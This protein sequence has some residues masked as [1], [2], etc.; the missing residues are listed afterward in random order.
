MTINNI[1][2]NTTINNDT[3]ISQLYNTIKQ[4]N[5]LDLVQLDP[6]SYTN[7]R[8]FQ[9]LL[10]IIKFEF[11]LTN[12]PDESQLIDKLNIELTTTNNTTST[13]TG[14]YLDTFIKLKSSDLLT[15]YQFLYTQE[16]PN[17]I[18]L[19]N[20]KIVIINSITDKSLSLSI[21]SSIQI[22]ILQLY[23]LSNFDFRKK[24]I[25]NYLIENLSEE[26]NEY[27]TDSSPFVTFELFQSYCTDQFGYGSFFQIFHS[28]IL[29]S[30]WIEN[31]IVNLNNYYKSIKIET[32][33]KLLNIDTDFNIESLL[34]KLIIEQ[35][36][37]NGSKIDQ[38]NK[39]LIFG[40]EFEN[41]SNNSLNNHVKKIGKLV[42][43]I[44]VNI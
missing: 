30:N 18:N 7:D 41:K 16:Q 32:I 2:N 34:F 9:Y 12:Y 43:E 17:L 8:K 42:N 38:I 19:I 11:L 44:Y 36:L 14:D 25:K 22:K 29:I 20:K 39:I 1:L 6:S 28:D 35:K 21:I 5:K 24:Q 33:Y 13:S 37:S 23:L 3:R 31:N 27:L 40:D 26:Y 4:F 15:D 10:I